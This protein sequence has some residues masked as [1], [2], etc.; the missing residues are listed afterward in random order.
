MLLQLCAQVTRWAQSRWHRALL[1]HEL[2]QSLAAL[3]HGFSG[4]KEQMQCEAL[5][6]C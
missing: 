6:L 2:L 5:A 1:L 3:W 4:Y